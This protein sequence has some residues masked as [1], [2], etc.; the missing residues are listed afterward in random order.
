MVINYNNYYANRFYN[1]AFKAD[2]VEA[3]ILTKP[4]ET[5]QKTTET[6]VDTFDKTTDKK[7]KK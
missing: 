6:V 1:T 2:K 4:I 5:V 3:G 7:K